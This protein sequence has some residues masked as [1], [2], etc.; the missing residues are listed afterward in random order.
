MSVYFQPE[1]YRRANRCSG[2]TS[3]HGTVGG[4]AQDTPR[5]SGASPRGGVEQRTGAAGSG[6]GAL[7]CQA[8]RRGGIRED[9]RGAEQGSSGTNRHDSSDHG[10]RVSILTLADGLI[11]V[12]NDFAEVRISSASVRRSCRS[13]TLLLS[14]CKLRETRWHAASL[15]IRFGAIRD[16]ARAGR[17]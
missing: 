4:S 12:N 2:T 11:C 9:G 15:K 1:H 14:G 10:G 7:L 3:S 16:L 6:L 17:R 5:D 13:I 8:A